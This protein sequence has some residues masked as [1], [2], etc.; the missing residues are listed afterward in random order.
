[1]VSSP[2]GVRSALEATDHLTST[3][4]VLGHLVLSG[5]L[6]GE[7]IIERCCIA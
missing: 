6:L 7:G 4:S 3:K 1:M 2:T 5:E